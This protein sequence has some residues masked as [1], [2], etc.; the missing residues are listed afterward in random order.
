MRFFFLPTVGTSAI[1]TLRSELAT[2][3]AEK[4]K[5]HV[6]NK[7]PFFSFF[8]FFSCYLKSVSLRTKLMRSFVSSLIVMFGP[9]SP[10][11]LPSIFFL[12]K[13]FLVEDS[14]LYAHTHT[15]KGNKQKKKKRKKRSRKLL[16]LLLRVT[17][18][19]LICIIKNIEKGRITLHEKKVSK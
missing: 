18:L 15:H 17:H 7:G 12:K 4:K 14:Y 5:I 13:K 2:L 19:I 6:I 9:P 10:Y 16:L 3:Q 11:E 1:I 8:F